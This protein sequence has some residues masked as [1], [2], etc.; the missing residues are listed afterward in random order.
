[1]DMNDYSES[2][3]PYPGLPLGLGPLWTGEKGPTFQSFDNMTE[4]EKEHL[5]MRCKDAKTVKEKQ[6]VVSETASDMDIRV[7]AD[8]VGV[9]G[10]IST[11]RHQE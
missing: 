8:E 9:N 6:K 5:I 3:L 2:G 10:G 1:M 7:L 11:S 4:T